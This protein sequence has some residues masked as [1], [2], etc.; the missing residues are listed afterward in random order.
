MKDTYQFK[1]IEFKRYESWV[2]KGFFKSGDL[3]KTPFT[4]VMPPPNV[5]GKLHL[6][7]AWDQTLQDMIVRRKRMQGFDALYLPGMDHAGIATQAKVD[8]RLKLLGTDR[9]ELGREGFLKKAWAWKD[10]Y[11]QVIKSQWAAMGVSVDYEKERFTL[12]ETLNKA[13]NHTFIKLFNEGL[14]YRDYR[15][16][17]WDSQAKTA[18]SN[19]EVDFV[20]T[21]SKLY[22]ITYPFVEGDGFLEIATTRPETMFADQALMVNPLDERYIHFIGRQVFIPNTNI[23]IPVISDTYV[24]VTFGTGVVK[25]TPAHDPNDFEVGKRHHLDMPLCMDE[26][27]H[28]NALSGVYE[29]LD[30]FMCRKTLIEDLELKDLLPPLKTT[31]IKWG[32]LSVRESWL[33]QD[34]RYNGL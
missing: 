4:I 33:N 2:K 27:G 20:E 1:D 6:G 9:F 31:Q 25:V 12:D 23:K 22:H 24:D 26:T 28:M 7:H 21:Q 11:A 8:E 16:I 14:I 19:I 30:R 3:T 34:C 29:G 32:I 15:I 5:T 17:S 10:E 18:L 13:V